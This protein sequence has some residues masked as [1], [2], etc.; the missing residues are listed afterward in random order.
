MEDI[1]RGMAEING[2]D[3][4][5]NMGVIEGKVE[6]KATGKAN[7]YD[8]T[9]AG[10][11]IVLVQV[12]FHGLTKGVEDRTYDDQISFRN[13]GAEP[14]DSGSL[15]RFYDKDKANNDPNY[16]T[17]VGLVFSGCKEYHFN[18]WRGIANPIQKVLDALGVEPYFTSS[19]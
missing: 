3:D 13:K 6:V 5:T 19:C 2:L 4:E 16:A 8:S 11:L 15:L 18:K 12:Q 14:G 1:A 10:E 17:A 9:D 7:W